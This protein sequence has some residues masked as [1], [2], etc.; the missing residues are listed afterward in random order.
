MNV[1]FR[2]F[3]LRASVTLRLF[4]ALV[5]FFSSGILL[6]A[7]AQ[8]KNGIVVSGTLTDPSGNPI[9]AKIYIGRQGVGIQTSTSGAFTI[10]VTI[11]IP[12]RIIVEAAG[13]SLLDTLLSPGPPIHILRLRALAFTM[14]EVH[15]QEHAIRSYRPDRP[16]S[17]E[18]ITPAFFN[19][20]QAPS[21]SENFSRITGVTLQQT[22]AVCGAAELRLNGLEGGYTM[23]M[24]DSVPMIGALSAIY[25]LQGFPAQM[26]SAVEVTRGMG[27][28][29]T[30]SD[31]LGGVVNIVTPRNQAPGSGKVRI[32]AASQ[33]ELSLD[34][35]LN[36]NHGFTLAGQVYRLAKPGDKNADGY[37]DVPS[38]GRGSLALGWG[39]KLGNLGKARIYLRGYKEERQGG[40][41]NYSRFLRM[42]DSVYGEHI[43]TSRL[44]AIAGMAWTPIAL[45][46]LRDRSLIQQTTASFATHHQDAVYGLTGYLGRQHDGWAQHNA[47]V[48][49]GKFTWQ[50]GTSL[51]YLWYDDASPATANLAG[52]NA[53]QQT[54]T[55][56]ILAGATFRPS[57]TFQLEAG[58]RTDQNPHLGWLTSPRLLARWNALPWLIL[59]SS[60][61]RGYR[62]V[63]IFTEDHAALTGARI[64]TF[65]PTL[66][67][68]TGWSALAEA[69]IDLCRPSSPLEA[70]LIITSWQNTFQGK[71]LPDYT[72]NANQIY[73]SNE[74]GTTYNR[75]LS[76]SSQLAYNALSG[77]L[78]GTLTDYTTRTQE[79]AFRPVLLSAAWSAQADLGYRNS[80]T[81]TEF[82]L[83]SSI[84]GP[85]VMPLQPGDTRPLRSPAFGLLNI[86]MRQKLNGYF[87]L[88]AG[89]KNVLDYRPRF[90]PL[91]RP[92][93]PF[94]K[95]IVTGGPTFD[96]GY[97]YAPLTG[98][99]FF[100]G[101]D[102]SF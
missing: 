69:E 92:D 39:G 12:T 36:L 16:E 46:S 76:V 67:P 31:A 64:V 77:R 71:I 15:I 37:A 2:A 8:V 18:C 7:V 85:M 72:R 94:D 24:V 5:A 98:R 35:L 96:T 79:G 41:L 28:I 102:I 20:L 100:A 60:F 66:R 90:A 14:A 89:I 29:T 42:S 34:A 32:Y 70:D 75:G 23:I 73:Y 45:S 65:A 68:E 30:P 101:L 53:P 59:R 21:L 25:G 48:T 88:T 78:S 9:A 33:A 55:P 99:R 11:N 83:T 27:P 58:I 80:P 17:V 40:Q 57:T 38:A 56:G 47:H 62:T 61:G 91:S 97:S 82:N 84:L 81:A 95:S 10:P 6:P 3:S 51:R 87:S 22:C 50:A 49:T 26:A 44:E 86:Q 13:M 1:S 52:Q 54:I 19:Q 93:D 74:T 43:L 4:V 63:N